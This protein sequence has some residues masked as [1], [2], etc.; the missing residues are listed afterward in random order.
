MQEYLDQFTEHLTYERN[1]SPHT[2]RNYMSDL[3]Q[4]H[5]FLAP[6]DEDGNRRLTVRKGFYLRASFTSALLLRANSQASA[7]APRG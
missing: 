5:D 7:P 3:Q 2:L 1:V 6:A 4:F